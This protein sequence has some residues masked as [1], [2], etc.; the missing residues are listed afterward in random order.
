M[1]Y[2]VGYSA[3]SVLVAH[4]AVYVLSVQILSHL[5]IPENGSPEVHS[6]NM[7]TAI[8]YLTTQRQCHRTD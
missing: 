4:D 7:G 3:A 8:F 6:N 5:G 1:R 2:S